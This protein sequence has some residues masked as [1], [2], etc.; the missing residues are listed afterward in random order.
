M[1]DIEQKALAL[2]N[3]VADERYAIHY[4]ND[5]SPRQDYVEIEALCR[6]IEQHE[7]TKADFEAF[8]LEVSDALHAHFEDA[9]DWA[10]QGPLNRFILPKPVD[11]LV[12]ALQ[13]VG[14][15]TSGRASTERLAHDLRT[16]IEARGGKIVW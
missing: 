14:E 8:R 4:D 12:D 7:A 6:S 9:I 2:V 1:T 16:A 13:E 3:D 5:G 11:P 15:Q 10:K